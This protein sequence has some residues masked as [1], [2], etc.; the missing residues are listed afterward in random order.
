MST[1]VFLFLLI[2]VPLNDGFI[3]LDGPGYDNVAADRFLIVCGV[4]TIYKKNDGSRKSTD[5]GSELLN[6]E[7]EYLFRVDVGHSLDSTIQVPIAA[8]EEYCPGNGSGS[9]EHSMEEHVPTDILNIQEQWKLFSVSFPYEVS[10]EKIGA[11][12]GTGSAYES[13]AGGGGEE[14]GDQQKVYTALASVLVMSSRTA[15]Q[16]SLVLIQQSGKVYVSVLCYVCR[17]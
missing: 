11:E 14:K 17:V 6:T 1:S 15:K 5:L 12:I 2:S 9:G 4:D 16:S 10:I 13:K 7:I 3:I 8:F